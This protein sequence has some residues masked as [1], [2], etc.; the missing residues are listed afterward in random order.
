M[1]RTLPI[2]AAVVL[3]TFGLTVGCARPT[4]KKLIHF[5]WGMLTPSKLAEGTE[6]LQDLPF[7]GIAIASPWCWPFYSRGLGNGDS[8]VEMAKKI[9]WG[10]FTDNFMYMTGGK[11]VDWFDDKVWA[12]DGEILKNI[13]AIAKIGAAA[14]CKGI[15][16]DPEFVYW[17]QPSNTWKLSHQKRYKDKTFAEFEIMTR[18][19]GVQV[20]NAIEE[21]MPNT[22]FLALFWGSMGRFK[23]AAEVHDPKL[24]REVA[25]EDYYGLL[26]AFMCGILEGA[27]P[28]TRIIDGDEHSYYNRTAKMYKDTAKLVKEDV[29][30]TMI[31]EDLRAKYRKQVEIGHAVYADHLSNSQSTH[32]ESTYMPPEERGKWMEHNVY[33]GLT[34]SDHY[35]WF[36]DEKISYLRHLWI[37]PEMIPAINRGRDKAAAGEELDFNMDD[38]WARAH[39]KLMVAETCVLVPKTA[40]IAKLAAGVPTIDGK[41]DDA[42]WA[43]A[44]VLG[45]FLNFAISQLKTL[46]APTMAKMTFDDETLYIAVECKDPDM[47]SVSGPKFSQGDTWGGDAVDFVIATDPKDETYYHIKIGANNARWDARTHAGYDRCS[48]SKDSSWTGEFNTAVQK[49]P[50][51]WIIEMAIPWKTIG[52]EAPKADTKIKA[53]MIRRTHRWPRGNIELSSWSER[54][55]NR[56]PEAEHFG[57]WTFANK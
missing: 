22:N 34:S 39:E 2:L 51:G 30:Q 33:W 16:F 7:D 9:K 41:L 45:P 24:Y 19:R 40:K 23:D 50:D 42:A 10:R 20:I 29:V 13:R 14:G 25:K 43:K 52:C 4:E 12:D 48:G 44:T 18:K 53:N 54:R 26:N 5:G 21:Y 38:I 17:G 15:L 6:Q 47:K 8:R 37:T 35:V 1:N 31:P 56:C 27:D 32:N 36:Y 55:R 3:M 28:G 49:G 46:R 57:T 11:N